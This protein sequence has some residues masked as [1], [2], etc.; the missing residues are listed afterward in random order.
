MQPTKSIG[1]KILCALLLIGLIPV[2]TIPHLLLR[3][4]NGFYNTPLIL[5]LALA[6]AFLLLFDF[7]KTKI[8]S[9]V[10]A[11]LLAIALPLASYYFIETLQNHSKFSVDSALIMNLALILG[12][13]LAIAAISGRPR[14]AAWIGLPLFLIP[15]IAN[16][17]VIAFR[18][19]ALLPWDIA[20]AKTAMNVLDNFTFSIREDLLLSLVLSLTLSAC[21]LHFFPKRFERRWLSS[22]GCL[23]ASIGA[24]LFFSLGLGRFS[25]T[26][27]NWNQTASSQKNGFL[28]NYALNL[29]SLRQAP[30]EGYSLDRVA[31]ILADYESN[32]L[33]PGEELPDVVVIMNEA[34]SDL[35]LRHLHLSED[36]ISFVRSLKDAENTVTGEIIVPAFGGGTCNTEYEF[37][38]SN[39]RGMLRAGSYPMQQF[40]DA[41]ST[42]IASGLKEL[43]YQ[44]V[45]IHPFNGNGWNRNS[46]YPLLGFDQFLTIDDFSPDSQ[47]LRRYISDRACYAKILET[48]DQATAPIFT[49]TVTMQN[50]GGYTEAANTVPDTLTFDGQQQYPQT[51]MYLELCKESDR[52]TQELI[53][54]LSKRKRKTIV[55][56]FGDH[57]PSLSSEYD[58]L[59]PASTG[60]GFDAAEQR[61]A[62]PFFLWANFDIEEEHGATISPNFLAPLL[63]KKA[64]LPLTAYQQYLLD[65]NRDLPIVSGVFC[66]DRAGQNFSF[67]RENSY[68]EQILDYHILQYHNVFDKKHLL[69]EKFSYGG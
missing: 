26:V 11:T 27:D 31:E 30:P 5:F 2:Y 53:E 15:A 55:L 21:A 14:L 62:V 8:L 35:N 10:V 56:F 47:K 44:T 16:H 4:D 68:E 49:F 39:V 60:M 29:Q 51:K 42:S 40:I 6:S 12:V 19:S 32:R 28:L 65:L 24:F 45:G 20:A 9:I 48:L 22:A 37:L 54:T 63:L 69:T 3:M 18:G 59:F 61:Y 1:R 50:H 34:F 13:D 66:R 41:K 25:L 17:Y 64:G 7:K 52:A 57:Q 36:P 67:R 38:A 58:A 43:G 23:A 46:A 33:A